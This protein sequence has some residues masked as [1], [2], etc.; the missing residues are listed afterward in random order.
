VPRF[1][2]EIMKNEKNNFVMCARQICTLVS[3]VIIALGV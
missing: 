3:P 2:P 1:L